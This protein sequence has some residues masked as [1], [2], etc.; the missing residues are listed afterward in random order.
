MTIAISV[1]ARKTRS[2]KLSRTPFRRPIRFQSSSRRRAAAP[3]VSESEIAMSFKTIL[4]PTEQ[5]DL[6]NST[7]ETA[8]LL[9]RKFDSYIEGFALRIAI[10][11]TFAMGDVGSL[12]I[13]ALEQESA[14]NA[15]RTR[16]LFKNFMRD[17][18]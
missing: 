11:S 7:L 18:G 13:P 3:V 1:G 2:T 15:K 14:E 8:L 17:N 9:A 12:P 6:M 10:P 4:V 16:S 5:H